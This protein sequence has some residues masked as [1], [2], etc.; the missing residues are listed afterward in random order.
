MTLWR[1][2]RIVLGFAVAALWLPAVIYLRAEDSTEQ[3]FARVPLLVT[4]TFTLFVA[5][6]AYLLLRQKATLAACLAAGFLIGALGLALFTLTT[7]WQAGVGWAP[8]FLT[9]GPISAAAF[10]VVGLWGNDE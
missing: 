5:V 7:H 3:F 2:S 10:W 4:T 8:A 6:P 9:V 1:A